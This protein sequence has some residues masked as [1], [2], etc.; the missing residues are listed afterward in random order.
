[1]DR[2]FIRFRM[3]VKQSV[4]TPLME[5]IQGALDLHDAE[6]IFVRREGLTE[7]TSL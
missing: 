7:G 1:M 3:V 2:A 4:T 5:G 6:H